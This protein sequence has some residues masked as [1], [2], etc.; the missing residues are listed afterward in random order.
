MPEH[1][2]RGVERGLRRILERNPHFYLSYLHILPT[3]YTI[4]FARIEKITANVTPDL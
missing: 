4:A 2:K 1:T 3:F